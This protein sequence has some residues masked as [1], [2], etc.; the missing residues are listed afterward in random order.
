MFSDEK[1]E[2]PQGIVGNGIDIPVAITSWLHICQEN[3]ILISGNGVVIVM[4]LS[5]QIFNETTIKKYN[6]IRNF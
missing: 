1:G 6:F 3:N 2:T 5:D 4:S